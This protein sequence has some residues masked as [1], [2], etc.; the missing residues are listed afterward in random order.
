MKRFSKLIPAIVLL[1]V[2]A[3]MMSTATYAWFSMNNK[4]TVTG[5][6]VKTK[7]SSNLLIANDTAGATSKKDESAFT[8]TLSQEIKGIL[9]PVSTENAVNF[10]Y[11]V[12]AKADG[13]KNQSVDSSAL[14]AYDP[15]AAAVDSAAYMDAFSE[16]Y[17]VTPSSA[18]TLISGKDRAV[19][20]VEYS[21]QLKAT[22]TNSTVQYINLK[23]LELT[24]AGGAETST[25][26]RVA[27]FFEDITTGSSATAPAD[28]DKKGIYNVT[29][30]AN[31]N[32][33]VVS[34]TDA[35]SSDAS[36]YATN[37]QLIEVPQNSVKY[38]K[39]TVRLWLEG[40][41]TTCNN[42]TFM[43]LNDKW[44]LDI[45]LS[46]DDTVTGVNTI[47]KKP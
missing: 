26:H 21:F 25:A 43:A 45:E 23:K 36:L 31:F 29:S 13:S 16:A 11:T 32:D 44:T 40:Q 27:I 42:D 6:E 30:S 2:S 33:Q 19:A 1:L 3:I 12:D 7:V 10:F 41:D 17:S 37:S 39:V 35:Y 9:E 14:I 38:Y 46:L 15:S 5:M 24:Y 4:V 34:A 8:N 47:T 18:N 22:N 20:Y 28:G